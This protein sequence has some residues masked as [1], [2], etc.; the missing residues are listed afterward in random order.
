MKFSCDNEIKFQDIHTQNKKEKIKHEM[1]NK[2][3]KIILYD[4]IKKDI[5]VK[6]RILKSA[7]EPVSFYPVLG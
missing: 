3:R 4:Q 2:Q 1:K 5:L 7:W 6:C